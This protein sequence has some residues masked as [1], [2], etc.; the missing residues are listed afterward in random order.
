MKKSLA[1]LLLLV[2]SFAFAELST[3][4]TPSDPVPNLVSVEYAYLAPGGYTGLG[5]KYARTLWRGLLTQS[6]AFGVEGG[7]FYYTV[8]QYIQVGDAYTVFPVS[9]V[10]QYSL[11]LGDTFRTYLYGGALKSFAFAQQSPGMGTSDLSV[12]WPA[13]GLGLSATFKGLTARADLGSDMIGAGLAY[14]F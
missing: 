13:V 5:I 10:A 3:T 4:E 9:A 12:F 6:D 2:P 8:A 11:A 1:L 7:L 14:S